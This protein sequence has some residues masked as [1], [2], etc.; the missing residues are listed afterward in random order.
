M[1][2]KKPDPGPEY[3]LIRKLGQGRWK[4]AYRAWAKGR[5]TDVALLHF[6]SGEPEEIANDAVALLKLDSTN[7]YRS[8]LTK[9]HLIFEGLDGRKWILEELFERSL[10]QESPLSE[11]G[12]FARIARDLSRAVSCL[13]SQGYVHKDI[14]LDNCGLDYRD[15]AKIFDIGS[16]AREGSARPHTILSRAP[17]LLLEGGTDADAMLSYT[18]Q[19]DIWALGATL[20][21][22]R[23]GRYPFV[24]TAE[25]AERATLSRQVAEGNISRADAQVHKAKLD[26]EVVAQAAARNAGSKLA[27]EVARLFGGEM[28][29]L[30]TRML[31]FGERPTIEE[32]DEKWTAIAAPHLSTRAMALPAGPSWRR[33]LESI[34]LGKQ[35]ATPAQIERV[36]RN[37]EESPGLDAAERIE[38]GKLVQKARKEVADRA[39]AKRRTY[40]GLDPSF[41]E[42]DLES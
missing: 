42:I 8:Y 30:L 15:T 7:K 9:F 16:I 34:I 36:I 22:L 13:H 41:G 5:S 3:R 1:E 10:S 33:S 17:E 31:S 21:A 4:V 25:L 40:T 24:N 18:K 12:R 20:F 27:N 35:S 29:A 11:A 37:I 2:A 19:S 14:K 23:T 6:H 38:L 26:K 32:C 39:E 28:G